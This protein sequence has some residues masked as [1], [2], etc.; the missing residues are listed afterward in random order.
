MDQIEIDKLLKLKECVLAQLKESGM[1]EM[2]L[3]R[4]EKYVENLI[5]EKIN[6][7]KK[8]KQCSHEIDLSDRYAQT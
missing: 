1:H 5:N 7:E 6:A 8:K 2:Y 4:I 3:H